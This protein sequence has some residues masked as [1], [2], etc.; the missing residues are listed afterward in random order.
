[1]LI[2]SHAS[3]IGGTGTINATG[4]NL[5]FRDTLEKIFPGED[6]QIS[7]LS[8]MAFAVPPMVGYM[9]ASWI[10]VQF[11]FLGWRHLFTLFNETTAEEK[12]DETRARRAVDKAYD[13]LG[14]MTC[15][16]AF[17]VERGRT[18]LDSLKSQRWPFLGLR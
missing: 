12:E 16:L 15:V 8:W 11:Q 3:L 1:M 7:Y 5:I 14:P 2:V 18:C 13:E 10:L 9:F 17:D 4:P 6:T